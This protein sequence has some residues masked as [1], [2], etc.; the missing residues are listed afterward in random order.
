MYEQAAIH[1]LHEDAIEP[2]QTL[3]LKNLSIKFHVFH[4]F[5]Q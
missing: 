4:K 5:F 1:W 2:N 3:A